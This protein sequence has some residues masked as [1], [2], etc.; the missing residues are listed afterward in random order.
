VLVGKQMLSKGHDFPGV[1]LVGI[2]QGDHGLAMPD[3]RS[4]ERTFALLTQVAGRAGR[5]ERPGRVLIQAWAIDHPAIAFARTH[6]YEGFAKVE[7]ES[8]RALGNPPFGH[9]ALVRI[10]GYVPAVVASRAREI[11]ARM[12]EAI[13]HVVARHDG[14]EVATLLGPV[15]SPIERIDRRTRW[16]LLLR[17]TDRAPL[18]WLLGELRARLGAQG[19]GADQT[20]AMVDVDPQSML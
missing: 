19:H 17:A 15:P 12:R 5:G 4:A 14:R 10:S 8:R 3:I 18:R 1:T 20:F 2:L 16:Q 9:L 13:A 11:G 6:D 7:L